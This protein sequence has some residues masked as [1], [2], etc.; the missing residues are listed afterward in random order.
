VALALPPLTVGVA[1]VNTELA[2]FTTLCLPFL[3]AGLVSGSYAVGRAWFRIADRSPS[4][5][6]PHQ[7]RV[8]QGTARFQ[9]SSAAG[10]LGGRRAEQRGRRDE[11]PRPVQRGK[12]PA[13]DLVIHGSTRQALLLRSDTH[14]PVRP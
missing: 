6:F 10:C 13:D 7:A 14:P 9:A 3:T 8:S 11:C 5:C 12:S 2:W 4:R 1:G